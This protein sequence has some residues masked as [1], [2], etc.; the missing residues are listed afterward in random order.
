MSFT[1]LTH[2]RCRLGLPTER[3]V[4]IRLSARPVNLLSHRR[5]V[6]TNKGK[7]I[8]PVVNPYVIQ[9]KRHRPLMDL[10]GFVETVEARERLPQIKI[11]RANI[12]IAANSFAGLLNCFV[13]SP[14]L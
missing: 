7:I 9:L 3:K 2:K 6:T 14:N 5:H 10:S 11:R 13:E 12:R 4:L 1:R 8:K